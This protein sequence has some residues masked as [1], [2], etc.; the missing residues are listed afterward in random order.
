MIR[1]KMLREAAQRHATHIGYFYKANVNECSRPRKT[2]GAVMGTRECSL[3]GNIHSKLVRSE[4]MDPVGYLSSA[5]REPQ[6][7][8][9]R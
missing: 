9:Q 2:G 8:Y 4:R 3:G 5:L 6:H 7:G 1:L